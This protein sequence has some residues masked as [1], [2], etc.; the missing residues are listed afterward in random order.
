[1]YD[2]YELSAE[3]LSL[4][5]PDG[6]DLITLTDPQLHINGAFAL[7]SGG[8][9][10]ASGDRVFV[11]LRGRGQYVLTLNPRGDRRFQLAGS[12]QGNT[13]VFQAGGD[14]F[15]IACTAPVT[16]NGDRAVYLFLNENANGGSSG[17]GSG[18]G[19]VS[20]PDRF[21]H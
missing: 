1:V 21:P 4:P 13:I 17:F 10:Q 16:Q 11:E 2:R 19:R 3:P 8:V 9:A 14:E 20:A 6:P 5:K 7:G 18:G 15:R 12:A